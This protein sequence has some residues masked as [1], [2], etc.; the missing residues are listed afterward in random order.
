MAAN[1]Y[2][3]PALADPT[4][5][6]TLA[7]DGSLLARFDTAELGAVFERVVALALASRL[8][9]ALQHVA[10]L[11]RWVFSFIVDK[12]DL[13]APPEEGP[14]SSV[15]SWGG[16]SDS[17]RLDGLRRLF[18]AR[19]RSSVLGSS[20]PPPPSVELAA[21]EV[22]LERDSESAIGEQCAEQDG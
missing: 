5:D 7:A 22:P 13:H 12:A 2:L 10:K 14:P 3:H 1:P 18:A 9:V 17:P 19:H 6:L 16:A 11:A 21:V 8:G 4:L 20:P 15:G